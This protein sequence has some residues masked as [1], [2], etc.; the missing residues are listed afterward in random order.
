MQRVTVRLEML[1]TLRIPS[2][3]S[4]LGAYTDAQRSLN[5]LLL[6]TH[7]MPMA[8]LIHFNTCAVQPMLSASMRCPP[9]GSTRLELDLARHGLAPGEG[10]WLSQAGGLTL[11]S[12]VGLGCVLLISRT[13]AFYMERAKSS[14]WSL[15]RLGPSL[16]PESLR[17]SSARAGYIARLLTLTPPTT[18]ATYPRLP[19]Q[20][21]ACDRDLVNSATRP[22]L[23][24]DP[25]AAEQAVPAVQPS[26]AAG[27]ALM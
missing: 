19:A 5:A 27:C 18:V 1:V 14:V 22:R 12:K 4:P 15:S 21:D 23:H 6:G 9:T 25:G 11:P 13:N 17:W 20:N 26:A 2:P 7:K 24:H 10:G 16:T 8:W 3:G